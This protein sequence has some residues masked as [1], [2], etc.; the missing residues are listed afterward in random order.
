MYYIVII[1]NKSSKHNLHV[2]FCH[3]CSSSITW[4]PIW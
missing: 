1:I 2:T 3:H 4:L